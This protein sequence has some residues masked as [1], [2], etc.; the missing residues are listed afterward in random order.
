M[1]SRISGKGVG[2]ETRSGTVDGWEDEQE[3]AWL[4]SDIQPVV[5]LDRV[6]YADDQTKMKEE[7]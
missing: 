4:L 1:K 7:R 2:N 6:S 3:A 5:Q